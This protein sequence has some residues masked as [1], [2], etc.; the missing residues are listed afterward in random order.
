MYFCINNISEKSQ[1]ISLLEL[2]LIGTE[3]W[4][5]LLTDKKFTA[6][7]N[8]ITLEPYQSFVDFK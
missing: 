7:D 1:K 8:Y 6:S 2:N 3:A 4:T 5:D